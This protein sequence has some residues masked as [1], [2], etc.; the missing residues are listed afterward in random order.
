VVDASLHESNF[1]L[2]GLTAMISDLHGFS[3]LKVLNLEFNAISAE[4]VEML[5]QES[6]RRGIEIILA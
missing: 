5:E 3:R 1:T 6:T 4:G 2:D